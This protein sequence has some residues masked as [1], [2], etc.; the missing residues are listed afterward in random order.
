MLPAGWIVQRAGCRARHDQSR[1]ER[2]RNGRIL[3]I[4]EGQ[5]GRHRPVLYLDDESR[6]QPTR[7]VHRPCPG[8]GAA[9][10]DRR[11]QPA[12]NASTDGADGAVSSFAPASA[13]TPDR[14]PRRLPGRTSSTPR[15]V[16]TVL[17]KSSGCDG[18]PDAGAVST[19]QIASGDGYMEFTAAET[20]TLRFVGSA[21]ATPGQPE[22][23][24]TFAFRLQ[25]GIAD[26]R[27]GGLYRA[28]VPIVAND[29]LRVQV[30]GGTVSYEKNGTTFYTSAKTPDVSSGGRRGAI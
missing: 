10:G 24:S 4:A 9:A 27:E 26:V 14:A 8:F 6:R 20:K 12:P 30:S 29:V 16:V 2:R 1:R 15:S 19:Q 18:C 17:Q 3:E 7:R 28:D 11:Q 13:A 5:P 23:P 22:P 25:N 21:A